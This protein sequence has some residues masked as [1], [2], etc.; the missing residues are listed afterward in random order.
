MRILDRSRSKAP[1]CLKQLTVWADRRDEIQFAMDQLD[2]YHAPW[3]L[4]QGP[5]GL[6]AVFIPGENDSDDS[7]TQG[8]NDASGGDNA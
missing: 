2:T 7:G 4:K 5:H 1:S 6:V 3:L 8:G